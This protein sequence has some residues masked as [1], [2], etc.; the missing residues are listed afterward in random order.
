MTNKE[1]DVIVYGATGFTGVL[2]ARYLHQEHE[3]TIGAPNAIKW[4]IAGRNANKLQAVKDELKLK[5]P[6]V[7]ASMIDAIPVVVAD[8]SNEEQVVDMVLKTKVVLTVVG[9]YHFYGEPIVKACAENGVHYCDLSAETLWIERMMQKYEAA[10]KKTGAILVNC[11]GFDSTPSDLTTLLLTDSVKKHN[12]SGT[13]KVSICFTELETGV[14]GGTFASVIS[15]LETSKTKDLLRIRDP[16]LLTDEKNKAQKKKDRLARANKSS[17]G[18]KYEKELRR[19]SSFFAGGDINAAIVHRSNYLQNNA[20]GDK[21]VYRERMAVGGFFK[22]I[23][24]T[25]GVTFGGIFLYAGPTRALIKRMLP[26]PGEGPSEE[27]MKNGKFIAQ[28][29]AY[30]DAGAV[31]ACS[32]TIGV[33]DPFYSMTSKVITETAFCL[34]KGELASMDVKNGGFF[35][36]ASAAGVHLAQRLHEKNIMRIDVQ[37]V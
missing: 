3:S 36:P 18:I 27:V 22:Q 23:L 21:F 5:V 35:T 34:A 30:D 32:T 25:V 11:C 7:P 10:A 29:V 4:A 17:I 15:T 2:V 37:A 24:M 31:A 13:S 26:P 9:P 20:Y 8:S 19:W 14:S 6:L 33:G 12:N 16:Y 1:F 28:G